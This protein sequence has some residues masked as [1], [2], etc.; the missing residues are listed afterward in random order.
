MRFVCAGTRYKLENNI[1]ATIERMS[2][3]SLSKLLKDFHIGNSPS[4]FSPGNRY[5]TNLASYTGRQNTTKKATDTKKTKKLKTKTRR[6]KT[7]KGP[8]GMNEE[9]P[10]RTQRTQ[11]KKANP[12]FVTLSSTDV[13]GISALLAHGYTAVH[14][15]RGKTVLKPPPAATALSRRRSRRKTGTSRAALRIEERRKE[16][17]ADWRKRRY[18]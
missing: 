16:L 15:M 11:R 5:G 8:G 12:G 13:E 18:K 17:M 9:R 4:S 1:C 3:N 10:Q 6:A 14:E 7:V 2:I